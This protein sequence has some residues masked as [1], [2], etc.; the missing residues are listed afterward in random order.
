MQPKYSL[1]TGGVRYWS[2]IWICDTGASSHSSND[3]L[4]AKNI[5]NSGIL[6]LGHTGEAVKTMKTIDIP[7]QFVTKDGSSVEGS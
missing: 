6:S 4:G 2:N 3:A 7:G 5:Q 1:K